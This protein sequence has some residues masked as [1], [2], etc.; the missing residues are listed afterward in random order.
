M[1]VI[2]FRAV[3]DNLKAD[4][5]DC[6]ALSQDRHVII[7]LHHNMNNNISKI[8]LVSSVNTPESEWERSDT[9]KS[10]KIKKRFGKKCC[11]LILPNFIQNEHNVM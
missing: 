3:V 1:N 7:N 5:Q 8:Y 10:L 2:S 4:N 9:N 6:F 11:G